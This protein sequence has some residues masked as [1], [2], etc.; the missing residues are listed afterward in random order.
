MTGQALHRV[1]GIGDKTHL[2][3]NGQK[4]VHS[5]IRSGSALLGALQVRTGSPAQPLWCKTQTK[6]ETKRTSENS[7]SRRYFLYTLAI[8][9]GYLAGFTN[10]QSRPE[11]P[12]EPNH[13][14]IGFF[15]IDID[16]AM[17]GSLNVPTN[18][19]NPAPSRVFSCTEKDYA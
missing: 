8:G 15:N 1:K 11:Q 19:R 18:F 9:P 10:V 17:A 14:M 13:T 16:P 2:T 4:S 5:H 12:A 3:K 6:Q 7:S